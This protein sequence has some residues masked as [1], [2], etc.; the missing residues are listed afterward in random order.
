MN[1]AAHTSKGVS[2]SIDTAD[3]Y[4]VLAHEISGTYRGVRLSGVDINFVRLIQNNIPDA[5]IS[6]ELI[7]AVRKWHKNKLK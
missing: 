1:I 3:K 6:D 5:A 7:A 2:V 4:G